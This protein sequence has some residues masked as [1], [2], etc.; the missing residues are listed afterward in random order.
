MV[1]MGL[2]KEFAEARTFVEEVMSLA[3][4]RNQVN[5]FECTSLIISAN[6]CACF[7]KLINYA[8]KWLVG[9]HSFY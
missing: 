2:D 4:D 9:D 6:D 5:L 7:P 3:P 8:K 1:I